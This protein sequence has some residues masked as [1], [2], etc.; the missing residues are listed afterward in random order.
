MNAWQRSEKKAGWQSGADSESRVDLRF[1]YGLFDQARH[2][3]LDHRA[4]KKVRV[5][6]G[7]EADRILEHKGAEIRRIQQILLHEPISIRQH[8]LHIGYVPVADV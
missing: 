8:T 4:F 2:S 3:P 5:H 7:Q 1:D 6:T